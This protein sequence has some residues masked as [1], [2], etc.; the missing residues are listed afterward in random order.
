[1]ASLNTA[2]R[3]SRVALVG[4]AALVS[5][6]AA[7][8]DTAKD[9]NAFILGNYTGMNTDVQG[10]VAVGGN[11]NF[12][13]FGVGSSLSSA[14]NGTDTLVVGGTATYSNGQV[15]HGNIVAGTL[16]VA[17]SVGLPNGTKRVGTGPVDFA[18]EAIRLK[19]LST[20]LAARTSNGTTGTTPW[21]ALT[22]TGT[23][24]SLNI[25]TLT[26]AQLA[27]ASS[28]TVNVPT[29]SIALFNVSGTS[30]QMQNFGYS[31]NG[32]GA[33]SILYNFYQATA[34]NISGIGVQGSLLAPLAAVN[35]SNGN[36]NGTLI[37]GSLFGSGEIHIAPFKGDLLT[38]TTAVPEPATWALMILG[39][40]AVGMAV[41]RRSRTIAFA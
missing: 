3:H 8:A 6:G 38:P 30:D 33:D 14:A 1:M 19:D 17:N 5:A 20:T 22:F 7:Q 23:S 27:S 11:A 28:F 10:R 15:F 24:A 16:A 21:G 39:F 41:R 12:T 40:G 36:L 37:A 26:G 13:S 32:I 4:L 25:F 31:L 35:F 9:Y 34:L 18:S 2:F 29:G